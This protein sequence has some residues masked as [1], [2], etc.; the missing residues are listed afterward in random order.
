MT[1]ARVVAKILKEILGKQQL[2]LIYLAYEVGKKE[3][4]SKMEKEINKFQRQ[5]KENV[6]EIRVLLQFMS[7]IKQKYGQ[8]K[9]NTRRNVL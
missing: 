3:M 5:N 9:K 8:K 6:D 2:A 1:K 7:I 4:I